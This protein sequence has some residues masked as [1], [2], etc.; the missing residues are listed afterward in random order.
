MDENK[1]G[2]E[3]Q[4]D[5]SLNGIVDGV[6]YENGI[7]THKGVIIQDGFVYYAGR[8]GV[9]AKGHHNVHREMS[10][11]ILKRGTYQFDDDGKL[12]ENYYKKP[13]SKTKRKVE[14]YV[15][16]KKKEI[17]SSYSKGKL[18]KGAKLAIPLLLFL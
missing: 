17:K 18:Q 15:K 14:K 4:I 2:Q 11:G 1:E 8:H 10:N 7:P 3:V 12:I 6:Y 13:V 5:E 16:K 9:L